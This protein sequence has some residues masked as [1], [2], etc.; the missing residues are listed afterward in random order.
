MKITL[1]KPVT[2]KEQEYKE[3]DIDLDS[4]EHMGFAAICPSNCNCKIG[5][6]RYVGRHIF[7]RVGVE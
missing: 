5:R 3:L 7:S 1:A 6:T 4:D 2:Y